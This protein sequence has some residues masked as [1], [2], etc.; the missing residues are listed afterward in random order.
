MAKKRKMNVN[1][2]REIEREREGERERLSSHFLEY[3]SAVL[4][5]GFGV[6]KGEGKI[7]A[8]TTNGDCSWEE[9]E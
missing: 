4:S 6:E 2:Q 9:R 7:N 1:R 8:R 5:R 3:K